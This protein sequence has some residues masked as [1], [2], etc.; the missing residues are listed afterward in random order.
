MK[1]LISFFIV[2]SSIMLTMTIASC[3]LSDLAMPES[4]T[5]KGKPG[6]HVPLGSPFVGDNENI[7]EKYLGTES[8]LKMMGDSGDGDSILDEMRIYEYAP[9]G[10]SSTTKTFI[11]HYQIAK[12]PYNLKQY[13]DEIYKIAPP[14]VE[15]IDLS[16]P[17][18]IE[19][20]FKGKSFSDLVNMD[21]AAIEDAIDDTIDDWVDQAAAGNAPDTGISAAQS[22]LTALSQA[23]AALK[24][25]L[26]ETT[27]A[28]IKNLSAVANAK[29]EAKSQFAKVKESVDELKKPRKIP[30]GDIAKLV[31]YIEVKDT[32]LKI[33]GTA[34]EGKIALAIPQ[35]GVGS[36]TGNVV[37][38][39]KGTTRGGDL[40]FTTDPTLDTVNA[41]D[42]SSTY[43]FSPSPSDPNLT[44]YINVL[45]FMDDGPVAFEP[46]LEFEWTEASIDPG[47]NG[48]LSGQYDMDLGDITSFLG[49]GF[50]PPTVTGYLYVDNLPI[51]K[52]GGSNKPKVSLQLIYNNGKPPFPLTNGTNGEEE[53]DNAT[54][55]QFPA[56]N[57][58]IF[59]GDLSSASLN[60]IDMTE[61]L[62]ADTGSS[63]KY[64]VTM[65]DENNPLTLKNEL[66]K[67][68]GVISADMVI[69]IPLEFRVNTTKETYN[70]ND[71]VLLDLKDADGKPLLPEITE[72]LFG[73]D[74]KGGTVD[75]IIGKDGIKSVKITLEKYVNEVLPGMAILVQCGSSEK[76]LDFNN[77]SPFLELETDDFQFPFKPTFKILIPCEEGEDYGVISIKNG[78]GTYDFDFNLVVDAQANLTMDFEL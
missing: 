33:T 2:V 66:G 57:G 13:M 54:L 20:Y 42:D 37:T 26:T 71:Y 1:K 7:V 10:S 40:Y 11:I 59:M 75:D 34:F 70:G 55:P 4:V 44:I 22:L 9:T 30:L 68:S 15:N 62:K 51:N 24:P 77:E 43:R 69:E 17:A 35:F 47:E 48:K 76:L 49:E 78:E 16:R 63:L 72:D 3:D 25:T 41:D 52:E 29:A 46:T 14:K 53:M 67:L 31:K 64:T 73:R 28:N 61:V 23:P 8:I 18:E 50:E 45:D 36:V 32:G 39:S 5:V 56:E 12:M 21:D 27:K 6:L 60:P 19:K 74:G 38:Y 65:G 58:G